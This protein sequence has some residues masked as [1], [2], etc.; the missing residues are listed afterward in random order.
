MYPALLAVRA[1]EALARGHR[2]L[3][4]DASPMSRPIV[5]QHG[6][7]LITYAQDHD[8]LRPSADG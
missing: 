7:Q 2:N 4:I 1:R 8:R 5:E 3:T 6:F